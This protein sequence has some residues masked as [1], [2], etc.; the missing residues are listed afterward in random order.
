MLISHTKTGDPSIEDVNSIAEE[1]C[2]SVNLGCGLGKTSCGMWSGGGEM[3]LIIIA[4]AV[5]AM[6][7]VPLFQLVKHIV[8][9]EPA[10]RE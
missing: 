2:C 6:V 1:S 5:F 7:V 3:P 10:A 8:D 9:K 4:I